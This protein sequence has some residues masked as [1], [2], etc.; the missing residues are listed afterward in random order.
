MTQNIMIQN[1]DRKVTIGVLGGAIGV[2]MVWLLGQYMGVTVPAEP[3]MAIQTVLIFLLQ[4][5]VP[6]KPIV[7][8]TDV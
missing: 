4:Y 1:P 2:L 8:N 3:A 7:I 5:I 6:N